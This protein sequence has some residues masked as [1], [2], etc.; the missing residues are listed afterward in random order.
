[1]KIDQ[2]GLYFD[3]SEADY[4]A[5]PCPTPSLTQSVAKILIEKSPRHAWVAH[6]RLNPSHEPDD[7]TK[8]DVG[9]VAHRILLGRGKE[10]EVIKFDD[11]RKKEA[12]ALR[13]EAREQGR[14]AVLEKHFTQATD[15]AAAVLSQLKH[16][17]AADAFTEGAGEVMLAWQEDGIWFRSLI[18]WLHVGN[19][20]VDDLK[21]TAMSVAPHVVGQMMASADW[22]LQAAFIERGLDH[23]FP[24]TAGRRRFRFV[25]VEDEAPHALTV[26]QMGEAAMTIGRKRLQFAMDR[27][28]ACIESGEWPSYINRIIV[29]EYPGWAESRWLE[30][31]IAEEEAPTI[32]PRGAM[33]TDLSGG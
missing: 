33:L 15:M 28:R 27:W 19:C 8:F 23:L 24:E 6:P 7:D 2:P 26:C 1:M 3:V 10:I 20:V 4:R 31:E 25:A 12:Q 14:I 5:D 13:E 21:T 11:W 30:R 16:H 17:E 29:P 9:N 18:D 32:A 22:P